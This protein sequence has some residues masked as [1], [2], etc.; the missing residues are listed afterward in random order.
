M[1]NPRLCSFDDAKNLAT[2]LAMIDR[3]WF[4]IIFDDAVET[5]FA[6]ID[7]KDHSLVLDAIEQQ[8]SHEAAIQTRNRKPLRIPNSLNATW[9]MRCGMNNR[10]R[11][12]Y[13]IDVE[14]RI[15]VV[16]AVGKKLGGRLH[17]G[18]EELEL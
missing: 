14:D 10:Y 9:E 15:V 8:L 1:L 5:H 3:S 11:V 2:I 18:N 13:D 16:L 4:E 6:A 17:I 7:R 12:F